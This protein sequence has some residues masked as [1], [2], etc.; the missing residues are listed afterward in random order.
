MHGGF[1]RQPEAGPEGLTAV[2][3]WEL[4]HLG[5]RLED[6]GWFCAKVWRFGSP[7][8]AGGVGTREHCWTPTPR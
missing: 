7:L 2:L 5:D 1:R 3:D 4:V 6:L 8:A